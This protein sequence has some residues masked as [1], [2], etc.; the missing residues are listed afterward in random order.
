MA[1]EQ[2]RQAQIPKNPKPMKQPEVA[3]APVKIEEKKKDEIEKKKSE[4]KEEGKK[5]EGENKK[6]ED[7]KPVKT[8]KPTIKKEEAVV[9][10]RNVPISTKYAVAIA[11]FIKNKPINESIKNLEKVKIKKLAVPMKGELAHRKGKKLNG[12]GMA[13][14][15]YPVKASQH[16]IKLLKALVANSTVNGLDLDK[17]H[18]NEVIVNKGPQQLH[19]F[20][21]TQFKRTHIMIKAKE[22]E[23]KEVKKK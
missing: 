20:G 8:T 22:F 17:T 11:N 6:V 15:K 19:R 18:I 13:S 12:K 1:D 5:V 23:E 4:G 7:K 14:G 9:Y 16:F 10:S 2:L 3:K 21:R